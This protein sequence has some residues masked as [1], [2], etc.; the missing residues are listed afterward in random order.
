M[1]DGM[2]TKEQCLEALRGFIE[3]ADRAELA[4]AQAAIIQYALGAPDLGARK[5]AMADLQGALAEGMNAQTSEEMQFAYYSVV[6][7]MI[8]RTREA[9]AERKPG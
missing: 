2:T 1:S 3:R 9:V 6:D 4:E 8:D 7:A 5:Q